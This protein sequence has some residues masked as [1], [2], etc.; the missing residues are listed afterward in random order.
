MP[1]IVTIAVSVVYY[2]VETIYTSHVCVGT[3]II[4]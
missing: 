4:Y 2:N 3:Y 1:T